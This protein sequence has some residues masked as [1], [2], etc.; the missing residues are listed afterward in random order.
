MMSAFTHKIPLMTEDG[1]IF[2]MNLMKMRE[3][4][5]HQ[6]LIP[7]HSESKT[8]SKGEFKSDSKIDA[9]RES[10]NRDACQQSFLIWLLT[11]IDYEIELNRLYKRGNITFQM[12]TI[13]S[14]QKD[15]R[16]VVDPNSFTFEYNGLKE[17]R[18]Y[19]D[20][21]TVNMMIELLIQ[22]GFEIEERKTRKVVKRNSIGMRRLMKISN[23]NVQFD[24]KEIIE[25][26]KECYL[27]IRNRISTRQ[28][29]LV[30]KNEL[31]HIVK[32]SSQQFYV[33]EE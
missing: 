15:G 32:S 5:H 16:T 6:E 13:K 23:G 7:P 8:E 19:T 31:S 21:V 1:K 33:Q 25:I 3:Q 22:E 12:Y 14:I 10:K 26:G 27:E 2:T 17:K 28:G 24:F 9:K 18:Q 11:S 4:H 29:Y 20:A 30:Q